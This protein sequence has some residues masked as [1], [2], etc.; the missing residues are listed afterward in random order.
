MIDCLNQLEKAR[1]RLAKS[2]AASSEIDEAIR[3]LKQY[4]QTVRINKDVFYDMQK[5]IEVLRREK[6]AIMTHH[7]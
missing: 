4:L 5:E 7:K 1:N 3:C 6:E 2:V